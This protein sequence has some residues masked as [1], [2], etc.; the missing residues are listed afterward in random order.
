M[1]SKVEAH[2]ALPCAA[3]AC[4]VYEHTQ[5]QKLDCLLGKHAAVKVTLCSIAQK[6]RGPHQTGPLGAG[7]TAFVSPRYHH[8]L[9]YCS[10]SSDTCEP[11]QKPYRAALA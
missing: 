11:Q 9:G 10:I 5:L 4:T 1:V 3:A 2:Q 8:T 6:A 7:A